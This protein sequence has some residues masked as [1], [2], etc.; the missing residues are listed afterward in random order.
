MAAGIGKWLDR[1]FLDL[2]VD[3]R[4]VA[5]SQLSVTPSKNQM[6]HDVVVTSRRKTKVALL[7]LA[8][9]YSMV[10]V[11]PHLTN[12][13]T[14]YADQLIR[15]QIENDLNINISL[16][17]HQKGSTYIMVCISVANMSL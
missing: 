17:V 4:R 2:K 15:T 1:S 12:I 6:N 5:T 10:P 16:F 14:A 8:L 7:R 3:E 11:R 13:P 9:C